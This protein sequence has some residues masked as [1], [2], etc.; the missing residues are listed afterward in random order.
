MEQ[1]KIGNVKDGFSLQ[2]VSYFLSLCG[3]VVESVTTSACHAGGR[4]F[5][6][7]QP[8]HLKYGRI[9]QLGEHRPY[10]PRVTGSSPVSPTI[11]TICS[12]AVVESVTTSACHAGGRGFES[13]QPR[14]FQSRRFLLWG[15][16][17]SLA[18]IDFD[19]NF[20]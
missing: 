19:R 13:R 7:R 5:E 4:G 2:S 12:G 16:P 11:F 10:K 8:R 17:L 1:L 3:A 20:L 18:V 6:S 14:H 15:S 9:A